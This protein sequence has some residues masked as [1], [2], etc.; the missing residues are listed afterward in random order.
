MVLQFFPAGPSPIAHANWFFIALCICFVLV[1]IYKNI[2][3][4]ENM[5]NIFPTEITV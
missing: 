2:K 5:Q 4:I 1:L 3:V